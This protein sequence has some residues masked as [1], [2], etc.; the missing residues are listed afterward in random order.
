MQTI[1]EIEVHTLRNWLQ[2]E[3]KIRLLDVRSVEEIRQGLIHPAEAL[4]LHLLPVKTDHLGLDEEIVVYCRSG[5]RS[6]Q[7]A[8][9]LEHRGYRH[10]FNLR[11]GILQ[12]AQLGL[13][14]APTA[15][16]LFG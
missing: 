15:N 11:G 12:W 3:R 9:Y 16:A 10:V 8:A 5:V 4:P 6:A 13:P 14:I 1:K 2:S 7:A